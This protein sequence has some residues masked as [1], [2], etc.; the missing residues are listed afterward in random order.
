MKAKV[1]AFSFFAFCLWFQV[2][3]SQ[4][5]VQSNY[6]SQQLVDSVLLGPGVMAFNITYTGSPQSIG[7]F[8][9]VNS[10]IGLDSGIILSSGK[11]ITAIG[12]N[13]NSSA[14]DAM[15]TPGDSILTV[16]AGLPT[17]DAAILEFDFI[18]S[19]DTIYFNY[20]FA[21]EEYYEG[22]CTVYNDIFA[23]LISGPSI[24]GI[25]NIAL[26]PSTMDPVS[27]SSINGGVLGAPLYN[28]SASYPWCRL[29]NTQY[30][31]DNTTPLG[32]TVQYDGFTVVL[33]AKVAVVRCATYH[34]KL[35][36]ADGGNDNTWDS[37]VFL[38]AGSFNS[39]YVSLTQ[40]PQ[41]LGASI[42]S[43]T[44]EGCG[45]AIIKLLQGKNNLILKK[46]E[47]YIKSFNL[48]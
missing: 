35:A 31:V 8:N 19:S 12:P 34:I 10:N 3:W 45:S 32:A 25:Q 29:N 17:K 24:T 11:I 7:F 20:V 4:L 6:T 39:H 9:G 30:Y 22:V 36:V 46:L 48:H 13:N 41:L 18:P 21:S 14:G 44:V 2:G 5:V 43:S 15:L 27:I 28:P 1:K 47:K 37:S 40:F 16:M 42:D 26:V 38:E 23:F 33:T